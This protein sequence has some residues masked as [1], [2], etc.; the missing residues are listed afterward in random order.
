MINIISILFCTIGIVYFII[1]IYQ[2]L[3]EINIV[4]K[5]KSMELYKQKVDIELISSVVMKSSMEFNPVEEMKL[6]NT[7]ASD[8]VSKYIT[9][10]V[11]GHHTIDS[12]EAAIHAEIPNDDRKA[13]IIDELTQ[14]TFILIS[15]AYRK[16][17][18]MLYFKGLEDMVRMEITRQINLALH[19]IISNRKT[20]SNLE[21][22]KKEIEAQSKIKD[23]LREFI[24]RYNIRDMR[25]ISKMAN[26]LKDFT[27]EDLKDFINSDSPSMSL[28]AQQFN[29]ILDMGD[30]INTGPSA[31]VSMLEDIH[32][33]NAADYN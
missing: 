14:S 33:A 24:K 25:P 3:S 20:I 16:R 10:F 2:W 6:I 5:E 15:D 1:G 31:I 8:L 4:K 29:D 21:L 28:M 19:T 12:K 26:D 18:E 30:L 9:V 27:K 17:I 23:N 32:R 7:I 11:C 22:K 13:I